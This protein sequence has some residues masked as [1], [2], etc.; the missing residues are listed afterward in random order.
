VACTDGFD[1]PRFFETM[2]EVDPT[3]YTAVPT[4]H[5][6]V[7]ARAESGRETIARRRLRF[8]RSSSSALPPR[9]MEELE[10]AFGVPVIEAYGMTE[11]SHQVASNALPPGVRKPG[12]V[13]PAAGP[14]VA[15][16]DDDGNVLAPGSPGEIVIRGENVAAAYENNPEANASSFSNGWFRTGDR[17]RVDEDGYVYIEGRVKEIINRGGEKISPREVDEV[18]L[19]H[20]AVDQAVT[21]AVPDPRLGEEV[22]AVVVLREGASVTE[23]EL[24]TFA[25]ARLA[26][27]KVPRRIVFAGEI[28]KGPT[29]KLQRI[30]LADK[31]GVSGVGARSP[32]GHVPPTSEAEVRLAAIWAAVLGV[33]SPGIHDDFFDTG[34]DSV[35]AA[36]LLS[37]AREALGVE[38]SLVDFFASPSIAGLA[39]AAAPDDLERLLAEVEA[40][41]DQEALEQLE[42][43]DGPP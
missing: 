43:G 1:A 15:I 42:E 28:P 7:L 6:A 31:L 12:S 9:V 16:V 27:F 8:V 25:A 17:G 19:D 13:G 30:G 22:A 3:W 20:P 18:L 38:V 37:R 4:M 34:G 32:A 36:Q 41:S 2:D 35:T 29:G 24:R 14:D 11:A 33:E 5:Q 26:D 39:A 10:A 23:R 21:F 40:L